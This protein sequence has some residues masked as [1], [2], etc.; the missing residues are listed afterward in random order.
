MQILC[1]TRLMVSRGLRSLRGRAAPVAHTKLA[2]QLGGAP[3]T[4]SNAFGPME[5]LKGD[6]KRGGKKKPNKIY[7]LSV[8][9]LRKLAFYA[10]GST[11][12]VVLLWCV[13]TCLVAD[14]QEFTLGFSGTLFF[15]ASLNVARFFFC[16]SPV[17]RSLSPSTLNNL[18]CSA[19]FTLRHLLQNY[20]RL[21][22]DNI[23]STKGS[24]P[25][26]RKAAFPWGPL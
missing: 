17:A 6:R 10:I 25:W 5:S 24:C 14:L 16:C 12:P 11:S 4:L 20:R 23:W 15:N 18:V 13:W 3:R 8:R 19:M 1:S 22:S 26:V 21:C 9:V 7:Y 2:H